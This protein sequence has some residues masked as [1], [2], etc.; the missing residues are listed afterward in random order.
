[1]FYITSLDS[2]ASI[3]VQV[4]NSHLASTGFFV[5]SAVNASK[6]EKFPPGDREL[7][8][9]IMLSRKAGDRC[10]ACAP[11][12]V[13]ILGNRDRTPLLFMFSSG[14]RAD[15]AAKL[16][17]DDLNLHISAGAVN[18]IFRETD[19]QE[20]AHLCCAGSYVA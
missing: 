16:C 1:M 7:R 17:V 20:T 2:S 3:E 12:P 10:S 14:A 5:V 4:N 11:D 9:M 6:R 18:E 19:G 13:T 15:E 8:R